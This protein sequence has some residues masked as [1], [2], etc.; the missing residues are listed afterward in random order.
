MATWVMTAEAAC[1]RLADMSATFLPEWNSDIRRFSSSLAKQLDE[2]AVI[3]AMNLELA[4]NHAL[5]IEG[6]MLRGF[7][8]TAAVYVRKPTNSIGARDQVRESQFSID[9]DYFS[10]IFHV[11]LKNDHTNGVSVVAIQR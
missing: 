9:V 2:H 5:G 3:N 6:E 10:I 8:G 7:S 11:Y 4:K 1:G